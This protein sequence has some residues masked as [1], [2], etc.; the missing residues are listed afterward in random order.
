MTDNDPVDQPESGDCHLAGNAGL[1]R[2][3]GKSG[4][5][6]FDNYE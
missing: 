5:K 3:P 1:I 2:Q 6:N 4:V